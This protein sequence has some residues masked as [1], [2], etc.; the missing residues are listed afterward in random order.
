MPTVIGSIVRDTYGEWPAKVCAPL[1]LLVAPHYGHRVLNRLAIYISVARVGSRCPM[2]SH[3]I[4]CN[5]QPGHIRS[6]MTRRVAIEL[7]NHA[8]RQSKSLFPTTRRSDVIDQ[9]P[10]FKFDLISRTW[11]IRTIGFPWISMKGQVGRR[12][13][14]DRS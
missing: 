11:E 3:I 12:L 8:G 6:T 2:G 14:N 4:V 1:Q 10:Q 9:R 7:H 5:V 13:I